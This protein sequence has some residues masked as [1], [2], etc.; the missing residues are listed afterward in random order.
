MIVN[1]LFAENRSDDQGGAM[2]NSDSIP[3]IANCRFIANTSRG[4]GA[5]ANDQTVDF[6][7]V[8]CLF[9]GN[10]AGHFGGAI[11]NDDCGQ[12]LVNCTFVG[13]RA[14]RAGAI[15]NDENA[16]RHRNCIFWDNQDYQGFNEDSQ[17]ND[18]ESQSVENCWV[19]GRTDEEPM[20]VDPGRW[21]DGRWIHGCYRLLAG[22]PCLDAGDNEFLEPEMLADLDGNPRVVNGTVDIGAFE[23]PALGL[24]VDQRSLE[25]DEHSQ[26]SL[27]VRLSAAPT[28]PVKVSI[29][30]SGDPDYPAL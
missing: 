25:V 28:G 6:H 16:M 14:V 21:Q 13:N 3:L 17:Y 11:Y 4:G 26:Q 7:V 10:S 15:F 1:C 2:F 9:A 29:A 19:Q 18:A 30:T 5:M 20:F 23:G 22:S 8:N 24:V 12:W 27:L